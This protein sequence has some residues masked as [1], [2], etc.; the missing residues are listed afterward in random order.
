M[1][2]I[3][4]WMAFQASAFSLPSVPDVPDLPD[5]HDVHEALGWVALLLLDAVPVPSVPLHAAGMF[6]VYGCLEC[7]IH[8]C[9]SKHPDRFLY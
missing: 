6:Q 7:Y 5:V 1:W 4:L 9:V 3:I 8:Q 2:S